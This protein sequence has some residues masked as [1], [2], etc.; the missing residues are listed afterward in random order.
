MKLH[1]LL[2]QG[3][4]VVARL[5]GGQ[6]VHEMAAD[7]LLFRIVVDVDSPADAD[8]RTDRDGSQDL[9][10]HPFRVREAA[11]RDGVGAIP[12]AEDAHFPAFAGVADIRLE[13]LAAKIDVA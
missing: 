12:D 1:A 7:G 10:H 9:L 6:A 2:F 5:G 3:W 11:D 4:V 8:T 13:N